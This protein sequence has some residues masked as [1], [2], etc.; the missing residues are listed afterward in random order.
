MNIDAASQ[1]V[2]V[3]FGTALLYAAITEAVKTL[4]PSSLWQKYIPAAFLAAGFFCAAAVLYYCPSQFK[5][6][7]SL[8][9]SL[10]SLGLAAFFAPAQK[11]WERL[12]FALYIL[13]AV[14]IMFFPK[15]MAESFRQQEYAKH[16]LI[17]A[18]LAAFALLKLAGFKK[19]D[20]GKAAA[21]LL[22][23]TAFQLIFYNAEK[24]S[25][26]AGNEETYSLTIQTPVKDNIGENEKNTDKKS[27]GDKQKRQTSK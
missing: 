18:P 1:T 3:L 27:A 21:I 2:H 7:S 24:G 15:A 19:R 9:F 14:F 16:L 10:L 20:T 13:A 17:S 23:I 26:S 12:Y 22:F 11:S 5:L 4:N 25:F 8:I 6:F